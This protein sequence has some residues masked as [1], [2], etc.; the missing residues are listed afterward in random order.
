MKTFPSESLLTLADWLY[1]ITIEK[2]D[3][4]PEDG[5]T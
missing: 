3:Q 4:M 1:L 5:R 2:T